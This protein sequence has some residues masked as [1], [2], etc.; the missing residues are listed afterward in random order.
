MSIRQLFLAGALAATL[1]AL[2]QPAPAAPAMA[3]PAGGTRPAVAPATA[4]TLREALIAARDNLDVAV[5]RGALAGARADILSADHAPLPTLSTSAESIDLKNGVGPGNTFSKKR[6]DKF[7]G[8]DWTIE[9]GNKRELRT[10][11]ARGAA[12]AAAADVEDTQIQQLETAL[13]AYYDLL[14]AQERQREVDAIADSATQISSTAQRRVQAGDLPAQDAARTEIETERARADAQQARLDRQRAT[15]ALAQAMDVRTGPDALR[16]ADGWPTL[17]GDATPLAD[18]ALL[19]E[20]RP[21]VRAAMARVASAQAGLDGA[22]AL[23]KSDVTIGA[24]YEHYPGV[25]TQLVNVRASMPLQWGY[26]YQGEIGRA[27]ANLTQAQDNLTK[28]RRDAALELQGLQQTALSAEQRARSYEKEILPRA[29]KVADNAELAF[30]RGAIPLFDLLDARRTL[31][32]TLLEAIA[33]RAD[34]AK[35]AGAWTLRTQPAQ[36]VSLP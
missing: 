19:A 32:A 34:Y 33:A 15:I 5:S 21:D 23:K 14:A 10:A 22:E 16:A 31:R 25:S 3:A 27:Q 30:R 13:G 35:A 9:R 17:P 24:S 18:Y 1:P 26:S 29:R 20:S 2:A 11:Q 12:D 6:I 7:I 8:L 36:L 4:L 28:V